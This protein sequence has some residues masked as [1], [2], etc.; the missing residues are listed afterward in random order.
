MALLARTALRINQPSHRSLAYTWLLR[1]ATSHTTTTTTSTQCS[2]SAGS[3]GSEQR[4][5][6]L[7][8]AITCYW[9]Q[10]GTTNTTCKQQTMHSQQL[11]QVNYSSG[12]S[13]R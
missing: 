3:R 5:L 1:C 13:L 11:E 9:Q 2:H 4:H 7:H 8:T 12:A 10:A 6:V